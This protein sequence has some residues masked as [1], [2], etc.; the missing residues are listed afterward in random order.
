M[1]FIYFISCRHKLTSA[2]VTDLLKLIH[3]LLPKPNQCLK[4]MHSLKKN[5]S[6][7]LHHIEPKHN[8]YC[9][10]C[11]SGISDDPCH[12]AE[13]V[14]DCVTADVGKQLQDK[15]RGMYT[16]FLESCICITFYIMP[17][18]YLYICRLSLHHGIALVICFFYPYT[19]TDK[20]FWIM[21]K[22]RPAS[23]PTCITDIYDGL[24]YAQHAKRGGFLCKSTNPANLSF[25]LNTDG[26]PVFKSSSTS[27]WPIFLVIN[28]LPTPAR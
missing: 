6:G 5:F 3:L 28:E 10:F 12:G 13:N 17:W 23:H 18:T 4:S 24:E 16:E 7:L 9:T 20:T 1:I 11:L 27:F 2:A 22:S 25:L 21:L 15:F 26:V 8:K 14:G 19:C